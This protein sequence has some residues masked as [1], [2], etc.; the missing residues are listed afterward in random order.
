MKQLVLIATGLLLVLSSVTVDAK[1][2]GGSR[3]NYGGGQHSSSHGG[4]YQNSSGKS[5]KGGTYK[6]SKSN[7][8]YGKH[9]D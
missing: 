3:S 7:D 4:H 9:K 2:N 1:G 5:H 8:Q 6:N